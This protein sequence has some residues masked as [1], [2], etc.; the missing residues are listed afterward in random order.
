M[1]FFACLVEKFRNFFMTDPNFSPTFPPTRINERGLQLVKHFEGLYLKAYRDEVGVI[2]IGWG[3]TGLQHR[4]GT[5]YMGRTITKAQA[6]EL[7]RYDMNQFEARVKAFVKVPLT[8]DQFSALVAFDFN[9]GKLN[10]STLLKKLNAGN[11]A[12]AA[13]EFVRWNQAGGKVLRG[14]TRRRLSERN[15]FMG[16]DPAIVSLAQISKELKLRA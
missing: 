15:L 5:V 16:R 8:S 14:L 13:N 4:D 7:L 10:Q 6:E 1:K 2:T 3:H 11:Y 12:G 9:L